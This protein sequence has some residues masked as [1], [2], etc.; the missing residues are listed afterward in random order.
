MPVPRKK[1]RLVFFGTADFAV[2]SLEALLAAGH[3]I[4]AVVTQPDKPQG[5]GMQ[6]VGLAGEKSGGTARPAG[7]TGRAA[8]VPNHF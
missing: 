4:L 1:L 5:R 8:F 3:E 7:N 6:L 2:P